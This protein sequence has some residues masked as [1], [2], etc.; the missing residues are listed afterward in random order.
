MKQQLINAW[1]KAVTNVHLAFP[2]H[3]IAYKRGIYGHP[4]TQIICTCGVRMVVR[5]PKPKAV[6]R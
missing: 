4:Y 6:K 3:R 1:N 5:N 2:G